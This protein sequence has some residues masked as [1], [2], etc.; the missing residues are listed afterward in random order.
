[1]K[2]YEHSAEKAQ[3]CFRF[4]SAASPSSPG[5]GCKHA[6]K[7]DYIRRWAEMVCYVSYRH[8]ER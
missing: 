3:V 6:L 7:R 1:M 5:S 2:R 8:G 4:V